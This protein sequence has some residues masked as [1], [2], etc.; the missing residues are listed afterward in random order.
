MKDDLK[1]TNEMRKMKKAENNHLHLRPKIGHT[2]AD[3]LIDKID[4]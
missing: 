2:F 1:T 4:R 3:D